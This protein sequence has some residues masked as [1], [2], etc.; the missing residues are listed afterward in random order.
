MLVHSSSGS[1]SSSN[2]S[3]P[4]LLIV[5][6]QS[7]TYLWSNTNTACTAVYFQYKTQSKH[8][9]LVS[10]TQC[11]HGHVAK[12]PESYQ[13]IWRHTHCLHIA[14]RHHDD[15]LLFLG[16]CDIIKAHDVICD[17]MKAH[18]VIWR[19]YDDVQLFL[20]HSD[21]IRTHDV[22]YIACGVELIY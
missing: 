6:Q 1:S 17:V 13:G 2:Y 22:I 16:H 9:K 14:W 12:Q 7:T 18:D 3:L 11:C 15:T 20:G 10:L 4:H 8:K 21:I 5:N 19:H